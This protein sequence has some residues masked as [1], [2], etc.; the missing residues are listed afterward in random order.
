MIFEIDSLV[1]GLLSSF[2]YPDFIKDSE[3]PI[4]EVFLQEFE[5]DPRRVCLEWFDQY[6]EGDYTRIVFTSEYIIVINEPDFENNFENNPSSHYRIVVSLQGW[7]KFL[8][9]NLSDFIQKKS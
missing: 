3:C 5:D 9:E 7:K 8:E 4:L 1:E 2:V 6:I